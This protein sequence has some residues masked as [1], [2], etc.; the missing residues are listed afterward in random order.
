MPL[1]KG[2]IA[3]DNYSLPK[4]NSEINKN[5]SEIIKFYSEVF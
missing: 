3:V 5:N 1:N 4:P 2:R